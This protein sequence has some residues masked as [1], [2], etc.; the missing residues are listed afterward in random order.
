MQIKC[1]VCGHE[2]DTTYV[3]HCLCKACRTSISV[4]DS[5][6]HYEQSAARALGT[7][8]GAMAAASRA[9]TGVLPPVARDEKGDPLKPAPAAPREAEKPRYVA[10]D[11]EFI[12]RRQEQLR[13]E[14]EARVVGDGASS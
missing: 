3:K 14:A 13:K 7:V 2:F 5:R 8:G 1:Y 9:A 4:P 12:R 6:R 10:D 11:F